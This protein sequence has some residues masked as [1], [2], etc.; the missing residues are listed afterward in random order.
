MEMAEF[1][2]ARRPHWEKLQKLL[3]QS[4]VQGLRGLSLDDARALGKLYRSVSSDLLWVRAR[5]GSAD[6]SAYLNDLVGRAYA[7]TYPGRRPRMADV[8]SFV[9]RGFPAL[10]RREWR[11]Y[12]AALLLLLAGAGFGYLGMLVDPDAA[13]YLVPAEH[14]D[15]DPTRRAAEEAVDQDMTVSQQAQFSSFLFTHNIQVAFLAFAL[16]AT[17]GLGTAVMLFVNGLFLG[18]LAQVYAA[19]GLAGWFWAWILP[20]GIPEITAICI[21]G[22]AGLV[23]ARAMVAP[24]GLQ[25]RQA[26]RVEAVTAVRLLFGTLALFV[27]AGFIEGTVSQI[28]PPKLSVAFKVTFALVVGSGVYSYLLSDWLRGGAPE[29]SRPVA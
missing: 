17:M 18:A 3:D 16:G 11:M 21:A 1:I 28:H 5:S 6:V 25:R 7:L 14:L 9:S 10:F 15:L 8:W 12:V 4:E 29:D 19:K 23:I 20:H 13:P 2:E 26:L 22:A 24:K 27:L